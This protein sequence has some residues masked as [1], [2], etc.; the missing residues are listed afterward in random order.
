M[1]KV[2]IISTLALTALI[3][4][5]YT[6]STKASQVPY[7]DCAERVAELSDTRILSRQTALRKARVWCRE[8]NTTDH[9]WFRSIIG[10]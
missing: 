4:V 6:E 7:L 10:H 2:S 8:L 9:L 1:K 5:G 3:L